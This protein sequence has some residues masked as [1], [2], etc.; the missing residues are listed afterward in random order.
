MDKYRVTVGQLVLSDPQDVF[1]QIQQTVREN[2]ETE[3]FVFPE[4][5]T[6][7]HIHLQSVEY[8]NENTKAQ[9]GHTSL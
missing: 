2:P 5:A 4:F 9:T 1:R 8:L 7:N 3:M 6:Q